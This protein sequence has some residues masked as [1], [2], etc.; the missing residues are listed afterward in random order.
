MPEEVS[1]PPLKR[2]RIDDAAAQS[3]QAGGDLR[4]YSWNVNGVQPFLQPSITSFLKRERSIGTARDHRGNAPS[5]PKASLRDF[6]RHHDW[7]TLL[8]LQEVKINPDDWATI[9]AVEKAVNDLHPNSGPTYKA[10]FC[11]PGDKYNARGFGRKVYGVCS[12]VRI[13]FQ[14][15]YVDSIHT[16]GWDKE[17]RVLVI[18]TKPISDL[19]KLA[20]INVYAVN[21]TEHPYRDPENGQV[22]GTR[23]DRKLQVHKLLQR[24]LRGLEDQGYGVVLAGD[25]NIARAT[26]D[27]HPN[28]RAFPRQH[29]LNRA[30]FEAR[31]FSTD[32]ISCD[33]GEDVPSDRGLGMLDTFRHLHPDKKGY[34][35]YPRHGQFGASCDRV[36]MIMTSRILLRHLAEAG[37]L[38]TTGDRATSDHVPLF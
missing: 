22:I 30:D 16:V 27:G 12:V 1:P 24:E 10:H 23:H 15:A 2:R 4:I 8:L 20:I 26:I 14:E 28:L 3:N 33:G 32:L 5:L 25:M 6:L 29:C 36:D 19:P 17:G 18:K 13:D 7:P 21:G 38:E 9:R 11:L 34:T 31:F 37:M 35:Y